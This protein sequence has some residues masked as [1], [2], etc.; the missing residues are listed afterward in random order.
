MKLPF[1]LLTST[2]CEKEQGNEH[3]LSKPSHV[4]T[5]CSNCT[6]DFAPY[7]SIFRDFFPGVSGAEIRPHF[8]CN[9]GDFFLLIW[10]KKNLNHS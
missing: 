10:R 2:F 4:K 3:I 9:L 5:L 1:Q 8:Q 6:A 7:M